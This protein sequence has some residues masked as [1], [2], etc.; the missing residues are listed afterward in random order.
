M[1]LF[2]AAKQMLAKAW[3]KPSVSLQEVE[4]HMNLMLI[5]QK[6]KMSS[7]INNS[8]AEV[9]KKFGTAI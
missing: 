7:T 1:Y 9:F 5:N 6:K 3:K 2:L 4:D 8:R